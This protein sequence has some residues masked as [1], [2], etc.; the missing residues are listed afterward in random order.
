M[1]RVEAHRVPDT[2]MRSEQLNGQVT[3]M[4]SDRD[5]V[6]DKLTKKFDWLKREFRCL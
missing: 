5:S 3:E 2:N 6:L 4:K 1:E